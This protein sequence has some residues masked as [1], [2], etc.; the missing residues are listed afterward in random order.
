MLELILC[1][2]WAVTAPMLIWSRWNGPVTFFNIVLAV[3]ALSGIG[4]LIKVRD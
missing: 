3:N 4:L 1:I 2:V